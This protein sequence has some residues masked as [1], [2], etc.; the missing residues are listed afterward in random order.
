MNEQ[1]FLK[2]LGRAVEKYGCKRM[3][4]ADMKRKWGF[5]DADWIRWRWKGSCFC[6]V[7]LVA[8]L[9]TGEF[10]EQNRVD[11][12]AKAIGLSRAIRN[13]IVNAADDVRGEAFTRDQITQ[14]WRTKILIAAGLGSVR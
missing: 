11:A 5:T 7:T 10:Y 6:P 2:A 13:R 1:E 14:R 4:K 8:K 12:A 3:T 9:I